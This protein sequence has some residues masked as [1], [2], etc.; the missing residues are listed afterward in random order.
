MYP[1][2]SPSWVRYLECVLLL[3]VVGKE[4]AER[5]RQC[6]VLSFPGTRHAENIPNNIDTFKFCFI[7]FSPN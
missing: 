6:V 5:C 3:F 2:I 1:N 7:S 4:M